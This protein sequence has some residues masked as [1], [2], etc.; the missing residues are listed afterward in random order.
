MAA[1]VCPLP[2]LPTS[3]PLSWEL[4]EGAE[5]ESFIGSCDTAGPFNVHASV[6]AEEGGASWW[7]E[8]SR[9][10]GEAGRQEV[11][12]AQGDASDLDE[13]QAFVRVALDA[14]WSMVRKTR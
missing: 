14:A 3:I 10:T 12:Y 13:A 2:T 7:A 5:T 8:I 6:I 9:P 4:D 1:T 11:F